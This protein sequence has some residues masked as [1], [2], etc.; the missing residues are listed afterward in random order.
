MQELVICVVIFLM[1]TVIYLSKLLFFTVAKCL[2]SNP[3]LKA[4]I[5]F[6]DWDF[7]GCETD[8]LYCYFDL[9]NIY[10]GNADKVFA[11]VK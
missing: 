1:K 11:I 6:S 10:K 3:F 8:Q 7:D 2:T 9:E 5:E 4:L